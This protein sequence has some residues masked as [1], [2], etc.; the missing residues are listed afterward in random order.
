M[1]I[2]ADGDIPVFD[3]ARAFE[4]AEGFTIEGV[5]GEGLT[6]I[7]ERR[8]IA[9]WHYPD[10]HVL[11]VEMQFRGSSDPVDR[12]PQAKALIELSV[13]GVVEQAAK[14]RQELTGYPPGS[15]A[16]GIDYATPNPDP[17]DEG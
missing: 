1:S 14:P 11:I 10:D 4:N 8:S 6:L 9:M 5:E 3:D 12:R 15:G 13:N 7:D 17:S 2:G 16:P